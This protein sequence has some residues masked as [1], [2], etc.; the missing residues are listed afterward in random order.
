MRTPYLFLFFVFH[1]IGA[2]YT[3][4]LV[5]YD[6]WWQSISGDAL[7]ERNH[8]DRIVHF[9]YGLLVTPAAVEI[10]AHYANAQ[11]VAC[12][13]AAQGSKGTDPFKGVRPL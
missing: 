2:H 7:E 4:S 13:S 8:Y 10:F 12:R 9:F 5:P 1:A 3:Y 6:D 11:H